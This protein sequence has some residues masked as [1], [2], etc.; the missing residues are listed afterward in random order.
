ML[1]VYI[2]IYIY[3][4]IPLIKVYLSTILPNNNLY[5]KLPITAISYRHQLLTEQSR[6]IKYDFSQSL[7]IKIFELKK[8]KK[9]IYFVFFLSVIN[10][11]FF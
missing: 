6:P 4:N 8:R 1:I 5:N 2:Y 11:E 10:H 9:Q 7:K 3:V